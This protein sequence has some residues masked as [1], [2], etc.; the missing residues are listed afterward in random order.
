MSIETLI[1]TLSDAGFDAHYGEA[2]D[3]TVCPY[4]VLTNISHP[5]FAADN[6]TFTK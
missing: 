1:A 4:V 5:N 2:P 3:G 6:R